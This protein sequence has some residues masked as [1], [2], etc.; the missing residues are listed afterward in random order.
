MILPLEQFTILI[1]DGM[2]SIAGVIPIAVT[3]KLKERVASVSE[4]N[5]TLFVSKIVASFPDIE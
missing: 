3:T 5:L 2:V 4:V 1:V